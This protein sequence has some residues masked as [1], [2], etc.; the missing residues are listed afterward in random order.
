MRSVACSIEEGGRRHLAVIGQHY[1]ESFASCYLQKSL[2][3]RR[4]Q[5]LAPPERAGRVITSDD[6][7]SNTHARDVEQNACLEFLLVE[8]MF[9]QISNADDAL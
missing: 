6:D 9:H 2:R 8:P 7:A 4:L 3:S 5:H 1:S